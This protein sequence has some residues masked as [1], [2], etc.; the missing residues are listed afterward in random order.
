MLITNESSGP[1]FRDALESILSSSTSIRIATGYIGYQEVRRYRQQIET[2]VSN[3]GNVQLIHGMAGKEGMPKRV[4]E[5]LS[6]LDSELKVSSTNSRVYVHTT[7]YHGKLYIGDCGLAPRVFVGSS[8]FS[9]SGLSLNTELNIELTDPTSMTDAQ[10]F[11]QRL[12]ANSY[13]LDRIDLPSR[14]EAEDAKAKAKTVVFDP[15]KLRLGDRCSLAINVTQGSNLNLFQSAGRLNRNTGVY[16]PRPFYEVELTIL[17]DDREAI[18]AQLP[19]QLEKAEFTAITDLGT[20][21]EVVFKR[22]TSSKEDPRTLK[23]T[24]LDFMSSPRDLLGE[25]I[26]GKLTSSGLLSFGQPVTEEILEDYGRSNIDLYFNPDG[27]IYI[28]F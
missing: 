3:G 26:K 28:E 7:R 5:E 8:N 11:F 23:Q 6:A 19:D 16:K 20:S 15:S 27:V 9:S 18:Q 14:T 22:K 17:K 25:Y 21:F 1:Q 13:P 4:Y 12:L 24:G 2:I 10:A